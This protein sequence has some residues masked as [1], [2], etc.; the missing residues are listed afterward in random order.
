MKDRTVTAEDEKPPD[1]PPARRRSGYEILEL[2]MRSK[3]LRTITGKLESGA[4]SAYTFHVL[5]ENGMQAVVK[6][7][8]TDGAAEAVRR[9]VASYEV[10]KL[11]GLTVVPPTVMRLHPSGDRL[12]K[13]STQLYVHGVDHRADF[14]AVPEQEIRDA[15]AFEL[16]TCQIDRQV[17]NW[18]VVHDAD[19][20]QLVFY[21][22]T[23]SFDLMPPDLTLPELR[24]W[25]PG[26]PLSMIYV[27]A[28]M[29]LGGP[30][31]ELLQ[32]LLEPDA[33]RSLEPYLTVDEIDKMLGR[34]AKAAAA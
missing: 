10:A 5:L 21:D 24:G 3:I 4:S 32:R 29:R 13:M 23:W 28:M 25:R 19:G 2:E 15:A 17:R 9:E 1:E 12:V 11:L 16:A 22:N 34:V 27:Y 26:T 6:A 8:T 20:D 31:L 30:N 18:G 7:A 14:S 33:T